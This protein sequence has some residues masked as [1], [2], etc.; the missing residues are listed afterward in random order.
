MHPDIMV[1]L[2][3]VIDELESQ[4]EVARRAAEKV[5]AR[6]GLLPPACALLTLSPSLSLISL[7]LFPS[8]PLS[9]THAHIHNHTCTRM[10]AQFVCVC[11]NVHVC[12]CMP[13]H[14]A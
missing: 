11:L 8:L 1:P 9:H 2:V 12:G 10:H 6:T 7:F 13:V 4:A 5:Q 3:G 14:T